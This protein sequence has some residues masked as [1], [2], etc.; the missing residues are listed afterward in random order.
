MKKGRSLD[1]DAALSAGENARANLPG[2]THEFF[3]A[4]RA[5]LAGAAAPADLHNFRLA[6]K[7]FRYTLELFRPVYGPGLEQKLDAVRRIQSL[8]GKRQDCEVLA[9]RLRLPAQ[10]A[11]PLRAALEKTER[12]ALKLEQEFRA[13]WLD[14]FDAPGREI[15]W[16]RYFLRRPPAP[17]SQ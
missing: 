12:Q 6:A 2:L 3:A 4:G 8:L 5:L 15:A 10:S 14:D 7:R 1:W 16:V 11:E 13:Y 17:R 9:G